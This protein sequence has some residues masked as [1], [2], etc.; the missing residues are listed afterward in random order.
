MKV[1]LSSVTTKIDS[2]LKSVE[3]LTKEHNNKS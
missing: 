3:T 2:I 1:L